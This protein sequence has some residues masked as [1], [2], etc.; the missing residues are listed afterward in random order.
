MKRREDISLKA[1]FNFLFILFLTKLKYFFYPQYSNKKNICTIIFPP[2]LGLGD[3]IILSKIVD[4]VLA[5]KK[6]KKVRVASSA[7]WIDN[8]RSEVDYFKLTDTNKL[9]NS[10]NFLFPTYTYLNHLIV[11]LLGKK[12]CIGYTRRYSFLYLNKEK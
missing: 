2:A 5:S 10:D 12:K 9:F 1:Y 6:Y 11:F 4:I 3:L 7:P 8:K